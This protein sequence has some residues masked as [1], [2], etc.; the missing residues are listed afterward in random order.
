MDTTVWFSS[1]KGTGRSEQSYARGKNARLS[2]AMSIQIRRARPDEAETLTA[3]A[4]AAKSHWGY[5]EEWIEQWKPDL[6]VTTDF[7]AENEM[8]VAIIDDEIGGCGALVIE[9]TQAEL[10][11]MWILPRYMGAGVGRSLFEKIRDRARELNVS[12]FEISSD[13]NAEGFYERMGATRIGVVR[14]E[15]AGQA[16]TLPRMK[17][18]L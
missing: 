13:P 1:P 2:A 18:Q 8:F 16:R 6:T 11:H 15:V 7:I 10:E 9:G 3:I 14:S 17:V 4:H 12:G 5:P